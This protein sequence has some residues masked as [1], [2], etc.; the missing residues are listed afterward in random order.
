M[1][2][3][4]ENERPDVD[5]LMEQIQKNMHNLHVADCLTSLENM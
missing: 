3:L 5:D 2:A 4:S 1:L